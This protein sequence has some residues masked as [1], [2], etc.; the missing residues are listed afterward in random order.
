MGNIH[1]LVDKL[2]DESDHLIGEETK[3]GD[4]YDKTAFANFDGPSETDISLSLI[5]GPPGNFLGSDGL[6]A[7]ERAFFDRKDLWTKFQK[8]FMA[9]QQK[10]TLK[11]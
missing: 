7:D 3:T 5:E 10:K 1:T 9:R 4:H 8:E 2:F 6:T 11:N